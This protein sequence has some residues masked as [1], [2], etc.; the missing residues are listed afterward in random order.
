MKLFYN[1]FYHIGQG[2][3]GI[4]RNPVMSTASLLVLICCMVVTGTFAL[5][6]DNINKNFETLED[7]NVMKV[8]LGKTAQ[9]TEQTDVSGEASDEASD[10][11]NG[12]E[13]TAPEVNTQYN[14]EE[15]DQA[16]MEAIQKIPHVMS[17]VHVTKQQAFE[18]MKEIQGDDDRWLSYFDPENRNPLRASYKITFNPDTDTEHI[19]YIKSAIMEMGFKEKDIAE[20]IDLFESLTSLKSALTTVALILLAVLFVVSLFIIIN[21]TRLG[22]HSRREEIQIM[23]Y[24]GATNT[25]VRA[26]FL[27]EGIIIGLVSAAIAFG[28]QYYVYEQI[29][30]DLIREYPVIYLENYGVYMP[31]VAIAFVALGVFTGLFGSIISIRKY[32]KV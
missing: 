11:A 21:S 28:L 12:E 22:L 27:T 13:S 2:I 7:I 16:T 9:E 18:E 31:Y 3:K 8:W 17:V 26:P 25:F 6:I 4:F 20:N 24:V 15:F 32:L 23:R 10:K 30:R 29:I 1:F 5:I 19:H 14:T